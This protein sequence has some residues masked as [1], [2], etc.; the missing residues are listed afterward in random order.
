MNNESK[1]AYLSVE[2][3]LEARTPTYSGGLARR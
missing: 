1:I 3:G 2:I